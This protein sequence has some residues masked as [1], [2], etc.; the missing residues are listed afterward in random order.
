MEVFVR[1][2]LPYILSLEVTTCSSD[3]RPFLAL[4]RPCS[5]LAIITTTL[6]EAGRGKSMFVAYLKASFARIGQIDAAWRR[7]ERLHVLQFGLPTG[8]PLWRHRPPC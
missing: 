6:Q 7:D 5:A 3:L 1:D 2:H 8:I 4:R